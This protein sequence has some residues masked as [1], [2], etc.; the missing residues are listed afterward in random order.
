MPCASGIIASSQVNEPVET[1]VAIRFDANLNLFKDANGTIPAT[2]EN[3]TVESWRTTSDSSIQIKADHLGGTVLIKLVNG[4]KSVDFK[5]INGNG[6]SNFR[7]L[8][9]GL[10][11]PEATMIV[12]AYLQTGTTNNL[13]HFF[14]QG[15]GWLNFNNLTCTEGFYAGANYYTAKANYDYNFPRNNPI[16]YVVKTNLATNKTFCYIYTN[17]LIKVGTINYGNNVATNTLN[18]HYIGNIDGQNF[19]NLFEFIIY[20]IALSETYISD[21]CAALKAKWL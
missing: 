4:K 17:S 2:A 16:I 3:D 19:Y 10:T 20:D 14:T 8:P 12:V 1:N 9:V 5:T 18:N 15:S 7:F 11:T 6:G 21:K 13:G